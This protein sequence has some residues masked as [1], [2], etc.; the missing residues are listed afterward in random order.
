MSRPQL[1]RRVLLIILALNVLITVVKLIVGFAT[2]A[3][4]VIADGFHSIIDSSSNIVGLAGLWVASRPPDDNHPYGHRKYESIATFA[5]GGMLLLVSWEIVQGIIERLTEHTLPNIS[6]L[7]IVIM[8]GT[9]FVNLA[10]VLYE[11]RQGRALKS[12][13]LLA[14]AAHTRTDLFVTISVVISLIATR[15]GLGWVDVLVAAAVVV[16]IVFAAVSIV[17]QTSAVLTDALVIDPQ[18]IEKTAAAV[19][20]VRHA[21]RARSRG[22]SDAAYVDVHVRVDP[23][24]S[25]V[26]AHAIASEVERQ[27]MNIVPG[28]VD[29]VVHI[30][31]HKPPVLSEWQ[32]IT[33]RARAEADALGI[34]IHDLHVHEETSGGYTVEMHVEVPAHLSL[35]E[36]HAIANNFEGRIRDA[37]PRVIGVTTHLEPLP[38]AVPDEEGRYEIQFDALVE[39]VAAIADSVAGPGTAHDVQLHHV[40]GHLTTSV[41]LTLPA[42]QPLTEAHALAEE[43]EQ[44]V[45]TELTQIKRVVVHVE[46][47]EQDSEQ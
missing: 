1:I 20:G 45:T 5:I 29:A 12:D 33:V 10:V 24:M 13:I 3:L 35:G 25:T 4:S 44:R 47:P 21:H 31:P 17:R 18:L 19:P 15:L 7:D 38:A 37:I 39:R 32:A 28:V 41:H 11:T 14:D 22:S 16:L 46:P 2:G 9:F 42:S 40:D 27:L 23:A 30:E 6:P 34:G 43:V 8:S 26:Q 36:A